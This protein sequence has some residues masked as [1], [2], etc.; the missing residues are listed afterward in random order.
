MLRTR[1]RDQWV[2]QHTGLTGG[3]S[4]PSLLATCCMLW[5]KP[6]F[7][8][9]GLSRALITWSKEKQYLDAWAAIREGLGLTA[10]CDNKG[11]N[12]MLA[13]VCLAA[14]QGRSQEKTP[15]VKKATNPSEVKKPLSVEHWAVIRKGKTPAGHYEALPASE[16]CW[17]MQELPR[18]EK[19]KC[20]ASQ[21]NEALKT[22]L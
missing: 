5:G 22:A 9:L 3:C 21:K 15:Q 8:H 13:Q 20:H 7:F 6:L 18:G 19:W 1:R 14:S 4:S 17:A 2:G 11:A 12:E 10:P 16:V